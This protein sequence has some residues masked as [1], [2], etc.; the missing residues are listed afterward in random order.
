MG[1]KNAADKNVILCGITPFHSSLVKSSIVL[2]L[3][4]NTAFSKLHLVRQEISH[5]TQ[6]QALPNLHGL[7]YRI[8]FLQNYRIPS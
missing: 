3:E 6:N 2:K 8:F 4:A 1:F 7:I 5:C